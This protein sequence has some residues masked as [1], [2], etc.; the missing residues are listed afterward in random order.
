VASSMTQGSY[1]VQHQQ[2]QQKQLP[3]IQ[4][5]VSENKLVLDGV[6]LNGLHALHQ[7][8]IKNLTDKKLSI[9]LRSNLGDQVAFQLTNENLPLSSSLGESSSDNQSRKKRE[10]LTDKSRRKLT[11]GSNKANDIL[12]IQGDNNATGL[13]SYGLSF[14]SSLNGS[15]PPGSVTSSSEP[16]SGQQSSHFLD[17]R[18]SIGSNEV[19]DHLDELSS[20]ERRSSTGTG[21]D[22]FSLP[23]I[24]TN[25]VTAAAIN[26]A[27][28]SS[29]VHGHHFNQLFNYVN[30]I[31]EIDLDPHQVQRLV[32]AF[33]PDEKKSKGRRVVQQSVNN[34][35]DDLLSSDTRTSS[36]IQQQQQQPLLQ[37]DQTSFDFF[38]VN[39]LLF[40]FVYDRSDKVLNVENGPLKPLLTDASG[41]LE[42][43]NVLTQSPDMAR[44]LS[45][46]SNAPAVEPSSTT[47]SISKTPSSRD[48][49]VGRS[50]REE[51]TPDY[52]VNFFRQL[53]FSNC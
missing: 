22:P 14:D 52:Q 43:S 42:G 9:K 48:F 34:Q 41:F 15:P 17:D 2:V 39:G 4:V 7:L 27:R 6:Y 51:S 21:D 37:D 28:R 36:V 50:L 23:L 44:E 1:S 30:Y 18:I 31:E 32:L 33:L 20:L 29:Y 53:F 19:K 40:F 25:T 10:H 26:S 13:Q 8:Y 12:Q 16:L 35:L 49:D 46:S 3:W 38:E 24:T 47:N 11:V 5:S 45:R